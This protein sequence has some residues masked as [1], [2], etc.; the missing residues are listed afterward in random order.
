MSEIN[1]RF[2]REVEEEITRS[3]RL[4]DARLQREMRKE[5]E[6]RVRELPAARE[7]PACPTCLGTEFTRTLV[8]Q[9]FDICRV[10]EYIAYY[11][12]YRGTYSSQLALNS[13]I[14][15][16]E[17]TCVVCKTSRYE[18]TANFESRYAAEAG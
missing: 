12:Y 4:R 9:T 15:V 5:V 1:I 3:E 17:V 6:E 18:R 13:G 16:L 11:R 7:T 2:P 14:E 10:T 8:K